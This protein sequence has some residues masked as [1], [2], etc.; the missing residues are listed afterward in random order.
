PGAQNMPKKA[1][2]SDADIILKL[3]DLR[4]EPEL[5]KARA[6]WVGEFFPDTAEDVF[7]V[8]SAGGTP[9]NNWFRQVLGYWGIAASLALNGAVN[10]KL[11][12]DPSFCGE[13][14]VVYV[15]LKPFL[16]QTRERM[17]SPRFLKNVEDLINSSKESR[18]WLTV[19]EMNV[20][21][22]KANAKSKA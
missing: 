22:M 11:F 6:W 3:Y 7:A 8:M 14:F 1:T 19:M 17:G 18:A 13:M 5:R 16:K 12:L 20:A 2:P 15:K 4:R 21:R 10:Q 9:Q